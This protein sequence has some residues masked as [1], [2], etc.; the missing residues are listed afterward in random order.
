MSKLV[1]NATFVHP[2]FLR[3]RPRFTSAYAAAAAAAVD[4]AKKKILQFSF[5]F[6][7]KCVS[8]WPEIW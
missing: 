5:F 3:V 8:Q 6:F 1:G 2:G 7:F 4:A